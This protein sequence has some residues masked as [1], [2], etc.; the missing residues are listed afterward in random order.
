MVMIMKK[1]SI[2]AV[3]ILFAAAAGFY[4][5]NIKT[6][7]IL[8]GG[9]ILLDRGVDKYLEKNGFDYPY[10]NIRDEIQKSHIAFANL[11]CPLTGRGKPALKRPELIFRGSTENASALKAAGFDVL[12]LANNHTMDQGREGL[13]DTIELL[14]S[15]GLR[16]LGAG[17]SRYEARK[18]VF[19]EKESTRIGFLGYND[20]P[21]EGYIVDEDKADVARPDIKTLGEEVKAAREQ[22]DFLVVSFHWGKEFDRYPG[23]RQREMAHTAIDSGAGI[24]IGHHPHILQN[25]EEYEGKLIFYS[26]GNFVFDRQL[27]EGTDETVML[28]M[29]VAD[30]D[31]SE[32]RVIPVKIEECRPVIMH[33]QEAEDVLGRYRDLSEGYGAG[34]E[35]KEGIGYIQTK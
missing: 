23:E 9:D 11:E 29:A 28:D 26:L 22:C 30:G 32:V 24:V 21:P 18:P 1:L 14:E 12:N 25:V 13:M 27:H 8:V 4:M 16:V 6:V 10:N 7:H 15:S 35:I 33:G 19:I 5:N 17:S 31:C 20:F 3:V 34:L 2:A